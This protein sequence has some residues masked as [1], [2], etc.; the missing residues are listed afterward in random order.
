MRSIVLVG[1]LLFCAPQAHAGRIFTFLEGQVI[2]RS[3]TRLVIATLDGTYWI[4]AKR[5]L[6]WL[7]KIDGSKTHISFWVRIDQIQRFR[8]HE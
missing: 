4:S 3:S 6:N 1:M 8:P 7:R 5:P 2:D